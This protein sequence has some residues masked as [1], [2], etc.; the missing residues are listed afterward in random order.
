MNT[1]KNLFILLFALILFIAGCSSSAPD[2]NGVYVNH[3]SGEFSIADDTLVVE[4]V[5]ELDYLIH[6]K[7][8]YRQIDEN[9][10]AGKVIF[11]SEVWKAVYDEGSGTM[12]ERSKDRL[13]SFD[14]AK[15][16]LKLENSTYQRIN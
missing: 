2:L 6:R 14:L 15:G 11:E 10:E 1:L 13:L 5:A 8:G 3:T 7:T 4:H 16:L 9:G 12:T